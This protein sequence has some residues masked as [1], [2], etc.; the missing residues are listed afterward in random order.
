MLTQGHALILFRLKVG[1]HKETQYD[2]QAVGNVS[3]PDCDIICVR[4]QTQQHLSHH[5]ACVPTMPFHSHPAALVEPLVLVIGLHCWNLPAAPIHP[6]LKCP[7]HWGGDLSQEQSYRLQQRMVDGE[8][9]REKRKCGA[10]HQN[11][12]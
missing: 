7:L 10:Q 5:K 3:E 4:I 12:N 11:D 2:L 6:G 1:K 8:L 9:S